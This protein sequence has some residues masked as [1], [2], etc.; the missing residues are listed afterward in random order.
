MSESDTPL[1]HAIAAH[2]A[3]RLEEAQ[4]GYEQ[5]L[6]ERPA[7]PDALHFLGLLYFHRGNNDKA[8][9]LIEQALVQAPDN[10][11]VWNNL[12]NILFLW[13]RRAEA[14]GA[15]RRVTELEPA[16]VQP[17]YNLALLLR[18]D[19]KF[20]EAVYYFGEAIGRQPDF[21]RA[22]ES[23]GMLHY[24]LG[25]IPQAAEVYRVWAAREPDNPVA[26]HMAAATSG[27]NVPVRADEKYIARL[28]DK[29]AYHFDSNLKQLGYRA[30]ELVSCALAQH[31]DGSASLEILDAGCGTGLC[32]PLLQPLRHRLTGVD[33]SARML[34]HARERGGYDE[35]A[36]GEL[37]AFM[38]SHP[39]QF[40][41]V[42]SA[43]TLVYFG[44]LEEACAA[45]HA[46]LRDGGLLVFTLEA[47]LDEAADDYRLNVHGRYAHREAYARRALEQA[48]FS[49]LQIGREA[50]RRECLRDVVGYLV[51]AQRVS[52]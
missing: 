50:L 27:L 28:F 39:A 5:A 2:Q 45:A 6:R 25:E 31:F 14:Q 11:H 24:R 13:N 47:L 44:A 19:G 51:V 36:V 12:G 18:D 8:V 9:E 42:V 38:R 21:S 15:Y 49:V 33:L 4:A 7:D 46:T 34:E 41:A 1:V 26:R 43:D 30:P 32:G 22:Y 3:G 20:H 29:H 52:S 48:G 10:P 35:L 16:L 17:W 40:D 23:L 37:C